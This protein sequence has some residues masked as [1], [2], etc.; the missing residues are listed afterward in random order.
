ME[1]FKNMFD[2]NSGAL[3]MGLILRDM[4]Y[5]S[6]QNIEESIAGGAKVKLALYSRGG[7]ANVLCGIQKGSGDTCMLY[8]HHVESITHDRLKFSGKG[9]HAKRIKFSSPEEILKED[10]EWLFSQVNQ[11]SPY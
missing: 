5:Q 4:V 11:N 1:D 2:E 10:I 8:V 7:K 3:E 6:F 9:K